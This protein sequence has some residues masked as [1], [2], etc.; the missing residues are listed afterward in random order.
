M[1]KYTVIYRYLNI[2]EL[3]SIFHNYR[4][5]KHI[6]EIAMLKNKQGE[7]KLGLSKR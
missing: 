5:N 3:I 2:N 4:R 7:N 6:K 1:S